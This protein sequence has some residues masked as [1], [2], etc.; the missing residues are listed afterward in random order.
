MISTLCLPETSLKSNQVNAH[1][2]TV[3]S[4]SNLEYCIAAAWVDLVGG[5]YSSLGGDDWLAICG[6]I[7]EGELYK[8][9]FVWQ[10]S[11]VTKEWEAFD[12]ITNY[13]IVAPS[14]AI[15]I[16]QIDRIEATRKI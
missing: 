3:D 1:R 2:N 11:E 10:D 4:N 13:R 7:D 16:A 14:R 9:W 15:L 8:E 12:P 5:D 6:D